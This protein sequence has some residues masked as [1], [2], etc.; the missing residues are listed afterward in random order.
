M[1][2]LFPL[3]T[4]TLAFLVI[5]LLEAQGPGGGPPSRKHTANTARPLE[6]VPATER[7]PAK[8]KV[9][10]RKRSDEV[11]IRSN[12]IPDH[13]VGPFPNPG[14]PNEIT[15]Q[16]QDI[17]IP[18][19]PEPAA[20]ISFIHDGRGV[21][22]TFGITLDGVLIEPGTAEVWMGDR[23]SG[24]NYEALGN[25]VPLGLDANYGHV[26][27]TGKYHYHGI[28]TG[29][30]Q[31]LGAKPNAHSPM[32]G[33]AADGFPIYALNGYGNPQD[34]GS[35]ITELKSS[36][37][38]KEGT[39]PPQPEAPGGTYDGAFVQDYEYVEGLGTLDE[40]NGRFCVTPE[41]PDGTYAY[42]MTKDWPIVPRAYRGTPE[43]LR[44]PGGPGGPDGR[45]PG[46]PEGSRRG[47][48]GMEGEGRPPG[49]GPPPLR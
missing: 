45:P 13:K 49:G 46:G 5:S 17:V 14:N 39:R 43:N 11:S 25:A 7:T 10:I 30:M 9:S 22:Q 16:S 32:I 44:G 36:Y 20:E 34:A 8:N 2:I 1:K 47:G 42:F 40:C 41:F 27:P 37:R 3:V 21:P 4:G 12:G 15:E 33:W 19:N 48:P 35:G 28:P 26:Q 18:A 38:L 31:R 29:L 24:W 23:A 6:L